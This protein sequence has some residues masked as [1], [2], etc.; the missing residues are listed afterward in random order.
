MN[1]LAAAGGVVVVEVMLA[2]NAAEAP[3]RN[4]ALVCQP[5]KETLAGNILPP[6]EL[7]ANIRAGA[8]APS[9]GWMR[10]WSCARRPRFELRRSIFG[11]SGV[12]FLVHRGAGDG[13]RKNTPRIFV[14]ICK[15][16]PAAQ[17]ENRAK[18]QMCISHWQRA[19]V[20][21]GKIALYEGFRRSAFVS[22]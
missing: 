17:I 12:F 3:D 22:Q 11:S 1:R 10:T 6:S 18:K 9:G 7:F 14:R 20:D 2:A 5:I 13:R 4:A 19:L 21:A 16:V 15:V 8:G